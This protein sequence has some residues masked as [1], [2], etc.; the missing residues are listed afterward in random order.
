MGVAQGG[1]T[2]TGVN[3]SNYLFYVLYISDQ[4]GN[5]GAK[6]IHREVLEVSLNYCISVTSQGILGPRIYTERFWKFH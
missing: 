4:S 2:E 3:F 5:T 6:N 1:D